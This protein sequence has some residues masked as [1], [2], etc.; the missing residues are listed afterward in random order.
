MTRAPTVAPEVASWIS[1]GR[2]DIALFADKGLGIKLHAEQVRAAEAILAGTAQYYELHWANRAGKTTLL[3]VLHMHRLFYKLG[4]AQPMNPREYAAWQN[5]EYRTLHASPLNELAGRA[6]SAIGDILTGTSR[7]Q[8]DENGKRREAPIAAFFVVTKERDQANADRMIL[9]CLN[10]AVTD[11]RSTEGKATRLEGGAWRLITWD[12][13]P[14]QENIDDIRTVLYVRLTNRAADFDAPIVLTGTVTP[15]TEHIAKEFI[16]FAEDPENGDWWGSAAPRSINPTTSS[17]AL[18]RAERNLDPEDYSRTVLGIPGGAKGRVLPAFL[19]EPTFTDKLP[20]FTPP[21]ITENEKWT[22]LHVWDLAIA[23]DENVG[24]IIRAPADWRFG[25]DE[26]LIGCHMKVIP[27]G[28]TLTS[29]EII[30]TI[31]EMYLPYKGLIVLDTTDAHGKS[32]QRELKSAGYPTEAFTFNERDSRKMIRKDAAI[33]AA[34]EIMSEGMAFVID[35]S[36]EPVHDADGVPIYDR[37]KPFGAIR[38]PRTWTKMYDQLSVLR[39]DDERQRRKDAAM[40]FIMGC[41]V[42]HRKRR[43]RIRRE[44]APTR[45]AIFGGGRTLENAWQR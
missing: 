18:Q 39:E 28:R 45:Y 32:I 26:P 21:E 41:E 17:V 34:R 40:T 25:V 10:G 2:T 4:I 20:R 5:E 35:G 43:A 27:G 42:A 12:E 31:Q 7:S 1:G 30:H 8:R 16:N 38:M 15:E 36:G 33:L 19:V 3:C 24:T 29:S 22:Y 6:F 37:D 9:R 44:K 13:W 14:Q 11:F 23:R